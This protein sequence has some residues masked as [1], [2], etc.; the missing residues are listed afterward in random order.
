MEEA[1]GEFW[2]F[3]LGAVV[4]AAYLVYVFIKDR[5]GKK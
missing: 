4:G 1:L 2:I 5:F 3:K